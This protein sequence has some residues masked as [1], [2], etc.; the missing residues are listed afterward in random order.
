MR[1][2][3]AFFT[4]LPGA[5]VCPGSLTDSQEGLFNHS[6]KQVLQLLPRP[7]MLTPRLRLVWLLL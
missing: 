5:S 1:S 7:Q 6:W 4:A 3:I 2:S